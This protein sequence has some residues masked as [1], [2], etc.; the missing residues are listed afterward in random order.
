MALVVM[1]FKFARLSR[2]VAV[3]T[4]S[5]PA[6][7]LRKMSP[8]VLAP[9][10]IAASVGTAVSIRLVVLPIESLASNSSVPAPPVANSFVVL[11]R[12][13]RD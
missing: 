12:P 9:A 5:T 3:P 2:P 10:L 4:V 8:A 13:R 11:V 1:P 6:V 7:W